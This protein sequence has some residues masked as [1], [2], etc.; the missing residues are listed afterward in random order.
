M[1][2]LRRQ[3]SKL[4]D[5]IHGCLSLC[6]WVSVRKFRLNRDCVVAT[7]TMY[8]SFLISFT[9]LFLSRPAGE[10]VFREH[11][12]KL[13]VE[14]I[15]VVCIFINRNVFSYFKPFNSFASNKPTGTGGE[16]VIT[17]GLFCEWKRSERKSLLHYIG[18]I[19]SD[20]ISRIS[21]F[22]AHTSLCQCLHGNIH[23]FKLITI[24]EF[25]FPASNTIPQTTIAA[26]T[27]ISAFDERRRIHRHSFLR[28]R[29]FWLL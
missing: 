6:V 10:S 4:C 24:T 20:K 23:R 15:Y 21:F 27:T 25:R 8:P 13:F 18:R 17:N 22:I 7:V 16:W 19:Q 28:L 14:L 29:F 11:L 9:F 5:V 1:Y 26:T 12:E 3:T 2:L